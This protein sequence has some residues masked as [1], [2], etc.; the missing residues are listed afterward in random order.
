M[1]LGIIAD[2]E[3]VTGFLLAGNRERNENSTNFMKE[4]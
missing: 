4:K 3:T 1:F 2:G